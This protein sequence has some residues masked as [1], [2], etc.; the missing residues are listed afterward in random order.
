MHK[1]A[2]VNSLTER[3]AIVIL[4]WNGVD[5]M[6]KYLPTVIENSVGDVIVADNASTDDSLKMLAEEFPDIRTIVLDK[7]Y[8]FAEGYNRALA[9]LKDEY[10]YLLLLN[11]DIEI[12]QKNWD[13][14]L[15]NYMD[16]HPECGACMP[17]LLS[18]RNPESFEYAGAS[19]GFIDR[20]GY[21]FCRGR[22]MGTVEEDKN[23]YDDIVPVL[24]ATGAAI[25]VRSKDYFEAGGLDSKFFAHME[26]IDLC[27]RMRTMGRKIV[28]I[29]QSTAYHLGGA[30]LNYGNPRK[31]FLNFR[32]NLLMLY[33][34]LP[35]KELKSVLFVRFILDMV[36]AL[37]M[38]LTGQFAHTWAV[39]KAEYTFYNIKKEWKSERQRIQSSRKEE[40]VAERTDYSLLW[41]Y[42]AKGHKKYNQLPQ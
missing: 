23:Q 38:L 13:E 16:A 15:I 4:N 20:Y 33:K 18:L 7:N 28:C 8:G 30:S 9:Q 32:N 22:V 29:P 41:Q 26:E 19:G 11:S 5:L 14:V 2:T 36:A 17:K 35:Q 25:M 34:N 24:W 39:L 21:P 3:E 27:W 12:R 6:R 1:L 37:Q 42:Y 10:E 31:T 40:R